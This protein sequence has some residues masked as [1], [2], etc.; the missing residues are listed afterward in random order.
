MVELIN[1]PAIVINYG[2]LYNVQ[3]INDVRNIAPVGWHIPSLSEVQTLAEYLQP[4]ALPLSNLIGGYLKEEGVLYWYPPNVG[5]SNSAGF[6]GRGSGARTS[7]SFS[8][9]NLFTGFWTLT[10][11]NSLQNHV[12]RLDYSS[13][14]M[15]FSKGSSFIIGSVYAGGP[16]RYI[17]DTFG[18]TEC[19]GNDGTS[20]PVVNIGVQTWTAA[21]SIETKYRNGDIIPKVEDQTAWNALSTGAYCYYNNLQSNSYTSIPQTIDLTDLYQSYFGVVPSSG[22]FVMVRLVP[23]ALNSG[24]FF[25]P[26]TIVT[27]IL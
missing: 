7:I 22:L 10:P 17:A 9:L 26:E 13:S 12:F 14:S 23:Y 16:V 3:A 20:Y 21:N 1:N 27:E 24:Q 4:G 6:F 18:T 15:Q 5:A 11:F 8:G 2:N 19:I 25:E